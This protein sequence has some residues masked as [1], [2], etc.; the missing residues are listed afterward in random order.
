MGIWGREKQ[1][2]FV[3]LPLCFNNDND[4]NNTVVLRNTTLGSSDNFSVLELAQLG[5][6]VMFPSEDTRIRVQV[7]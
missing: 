7:E 5:G 1:G 4:N 6:L 3:F 2:I